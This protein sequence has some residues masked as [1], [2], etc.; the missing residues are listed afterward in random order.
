MERSFV[1][2]VVP[3]YN[4]EKNI[5]SCLES[6]VSQT[7][8]KNRFE[9]LVIDNNC[10]DKTAEIAEKYG[11][12]VIKENRQGL[13][14]ARIKGADSAKGEIVA[15]ID[16]DTKANSDWLKQMVTVYQNDKRVV[17]VAQI[18]DP[19][20][21]NFLVNIFIP[22]AN[23]CDKALRIMPG[24]H[25]SFKKDAYL[26]SGGYSTKAT[27]YED[28]FISKKLKKIGKIVIQGKGPI[29]S[30]RRFSNLKSFS[31]YAAKGF[32][33]L[34]T[35]SLFGFSPFGFPQITKTKPSN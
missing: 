10:T 14:F 26:K 4:E 20:P 3:A 6:I 33:S 16:A 32:V 15:F 12:K 24:S 25:F 21:K 5:G 7:Y 11:A 29:S 22:F 34:V 17:G 35:I 2:V 9:I 13:V 27:F 18:L 19:Y 31:S 30:S 23:L 8:P 1:S 28:V